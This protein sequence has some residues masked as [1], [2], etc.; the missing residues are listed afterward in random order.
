MNE[1]PATTTYVRGASF[2][3]NKLRL[4]K[5]FET[6][7]PTSKGSITKEDLINAFTSARLTPMPTSKEWDDLIRSLEAWDRED[8]KIVAYRK[9]M[10]AHSTREP[11]SLYGIFPRAKGREPSKYELERKAKAEAEEK[12]KQEAEEQEKLKLAKLGGA[13]RS[14]SSSKQMSKDD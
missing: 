4:L 7:D 9:F 11:Q 1:V 13:K 10:E 14:G 8:D 6:Y 3:S 2:A 12:K 5:A